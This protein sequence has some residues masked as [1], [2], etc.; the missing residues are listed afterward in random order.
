MDLR[1]IPD[2]NKR[3]PECIQL[4]EGSCSNAFFVHD[5]LAMTIAASMDL[6]DT[7]DG[8]TYLAWTLEIIS[9]SMVHHTKRGVDAR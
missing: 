5:R 3:A 6:V 2:V 1:V 7:S 4:A 8:R 9:T